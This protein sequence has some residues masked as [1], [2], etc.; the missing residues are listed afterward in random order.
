MGCPLQAAENLQ[1][2]SFPVFGADKID[3]DRT[4][5]DPR[6]RVIFIGDTH[7]DFEALIR[8]FRKLNLLDRHWYRWIGQNTRVY[9]AGDLN[10]RGPETRR[11]INFV[12]HTNQLALADGGGVESINSNH[13][14]AWTRGIF[15][16]ASAEEHRSFFDLARGAQTGL[17]RVF[18]SH[19]GFGKW[20]SQLNSIIKV[21]PF[22]F[23]HAGFEEWLLERH[24]NEINST[25]RAW[26]DAYR[27]HDFQ[28]YPDESLEWVMGRQ[29]PLWTRR[30]AAGFFE[31]GYFSE[32]QKTL[33]PV[34]QSLVNEVLKKLSVEYAIIGHTVTASQEIEVGYQDQVFMIDTGISAYMKNPG[35]LT[36]LEWSERDGITRHV[37]ENRQSPKDKDAQLIHHARQT[38]P[39][40]L[41]SLDFPKSVKEKLIY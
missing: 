17:N 39:D 25:V 9:L 33:E 8:I 38:C 30:L 11:L 5:E 28:F 4:P 27:D 21:G 1:N 13:L 31:D 36:A 7:G 29:G 14:V 41:H 26:V 20:I 37:F 16:D 2:E 19:D 35:K 22:L 40:Y 6:S 24:P 15:E 10:D 34:S 3:W 23:S 32:G 12:I 18:S